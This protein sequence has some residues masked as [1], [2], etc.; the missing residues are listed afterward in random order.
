MLLFTAFI[1][2]QN[3]L[4]G[5]TYPEQ[6]KFAEAETFFEKI[7]KEYPNKKTQSCSTAGLLA[8]TESLR[9]LPPSLQNCCSNTRA[10]PSLK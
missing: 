3:L 2:A 9:P 8:A 5:F 10:R 6:G 7:V 4:E 1:S